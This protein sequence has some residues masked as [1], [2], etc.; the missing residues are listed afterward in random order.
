MLFRS[1]GGHR[2]RAIRD[3]KR[4][5]FKVDNRKFIQESEGYREIF[6]NID[7]PIDIKICSSQEAIRIFKDL[8]ETTHVNFIES[9]M[10]DD[11]SEICKYIRSTT[12]Y[13]PEYSNEAHD[14]FERITKPVGEVKS[15]WFEIAPNHRRK[16]DEYVAIAI[17]KA[18]GGGN[19]N[20]GQKQIEDIISQEYKG[21]N[22]LTSSV[23]NTVARYLDDVYMCQKHALGYKKLNTDRYAAFQLVW[24]EIFNKNNSFKIEDHEKFM[25]HFDGA[26][27]IY[28][29]N[30]D[31]T[32]NE[33]IIEFDGEHQL[34]KEFIRKNITN[35]SNSGVQKYCANI[36]L[37]EMGDLSNC[38]VIFREE[39]RSM[40]T[41]ERNELL[42]AQGYKCAIDGLPLSLEES[43][44][45][46]DTPWAKGG[47]ISDG[48]VIR[49]TH[50]VDMG[51]LTIDEYRKVL[52]MRKSN[53]NYTS[54]SE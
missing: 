34:V 33:K 39:K 7:V 1:D 38:G 21:N 44:L 27:S 52:D 30:I 42:S 29:G 54:K 43:V 37:E 6:L 20:A 36:L 35:F 3:Y 14:L 24:F 32:Y 13:Y 26:Y 46:H 28:T 9:I 47:K 12:T 18:A 2:I 48:A 16:W 23:K 25:S 5:K 15:K 51:S 10:C 41:K 22:I 50:N 4:G 31:K 45:G 53:K 40:R 8:N 19:V 11:Q 17:I 49:K